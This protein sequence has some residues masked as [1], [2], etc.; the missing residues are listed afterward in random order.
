VLLNN[1]GDGL[2]VTANG[3]FTFATAG[4]AGALYSV[5]VSIQPSGQ[6]CTVQNRQWHGQR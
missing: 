3:F 6:T 1:G 2:A 4:S 5:T